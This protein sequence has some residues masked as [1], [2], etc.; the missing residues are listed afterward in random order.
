MSDT[1]TITRRRI[2]WEPA[3]GPHPLPLGRNQFWDSRNLAYA[4]RRDPARTLT[5]QMWTRHTPI[6]DQGNVGSCTGNAE[7]GALE[8]Q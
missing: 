6:L 1:W 5:S 8:V 4:W 7:T 3:A 2:P